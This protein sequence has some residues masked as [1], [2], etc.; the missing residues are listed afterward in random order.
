[1]CG[2]Q[3]P[4]PSPL[5]PRFPA[6]CPGPLKSP[7]VE[8]VVEM[9]TEMAS[10]MSSINCSCPH[11]CGSHCRTFFSCQTRPQNWCYRWSSPPLCEGKTGRG[12]GQRYLL[13]SQTL[14]VKSLIWKYHQPAHQSRD[15]IIL[16][17]LFFCFSGFFFYLAVILFLLPNKLN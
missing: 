17:L 12:Y 2:L 8:E 5:P 7:C 13:S 16:F 1:M 3:L 9:R 10:V 6:L 14:I 15:S 11:C 4:S